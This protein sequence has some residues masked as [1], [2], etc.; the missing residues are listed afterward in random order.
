MSPRPSLKQYCSGICPP[1]TSLSISVSASSLHHKSP[2][3]SLLQLQL[4]TRAINIYVIN[5]SVLNQC[6]PPSLLQA[7]ASVILLLAAE[8]KVDPELEAQLKESTHLDPNLLSTR[9]R[10]PSSVS[11]LILRFHQRLQQQHGLEV[12]PEIYDEASN[13]SRSFEKDWGV[14]VSRFRIPR[15][16]KPGGGADAN[17]TSLPSHTS[18]ARPLSSSTPSGL[19]ETASLS[20]FVN[21]LLNYARTYIA[22]PLLAT[23]EESWCHLLAIDWLYMNQDVPGGTSSKGAIPF[24]KIPASTSEAPG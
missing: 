7:C 21:Y 18:H 8:A 19:T 1:L 16:A 24:G 3:T 4:S 15:L 20:P 23:A 9:A 22:T 12:D 2:A 6:R 17:H 10:E 14:R 13:S 5:I 11:L